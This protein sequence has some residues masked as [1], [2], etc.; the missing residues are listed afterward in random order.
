MTVKIKVLLQIKVK[1][2]T[3]KKITRRYFVTQNVISYYM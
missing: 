3:L 2:H 1:L